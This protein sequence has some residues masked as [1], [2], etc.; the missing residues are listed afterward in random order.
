M[1]ESSAQTHAC[2]YQGQ[3][4]CDSDVFR[5]WGIIK[6]GPGRLEVMNLV[7]ALVQGCKIKDERL[8][9]LLSEMFSASE[10]TN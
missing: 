6:N 8:I 7:G 4:L 1:R 2:G 9:G 10:P 5:A 3:N